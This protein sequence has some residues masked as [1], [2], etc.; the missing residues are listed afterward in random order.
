MN[1]EFLIVRSGQLRTTGVAKMLAALMAGQQHMHP[2]LQDHGWWKRNIRV[3]YRIP[4]GEREQVTQ[5]VFDPGNSSRPLLILGK[6]G[7]LG[8]A[9]ARI[10]KQRNIQYKLVGRDEVDISKPQTIERAI[11]QLNPWAVI[12]AAGYVRVDDAEV[13]MD[14]CYLANTTGPMHLAR[15]CKRHGVQLVSFSSDLVFDGKKMAAYQETDQVN[16]LNVYG[17]SKAIAEKYILE[18]CPD[19]LVVRTSAFFGPWDNYNFLAA[20][21]QSCKKGVPFAAPKDVIVSPTYV[22]GSGAYNA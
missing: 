16:P 15:S 21:L 5:E 1:P 4:M 11:E 7:T 2:V 12:N 22:P 3:Q 6:T 19:A 13:D 14:N 8:N 20:A 18:S 10:C 9:F 17:R